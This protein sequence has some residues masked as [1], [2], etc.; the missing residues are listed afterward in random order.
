MNEQT[1]TWVPFRVTLVDRN[2]VARRGLQ[3]MLR[4]LQA[5][6]DP[7]LVADV[8]AFGSAEAALTRIAEQQPNL[9]MVSSDLST[10]V[11]VLVR[12]AGD[13]LVLMLIRSPELG[14]LAAAFKTRAHGFVMEH[15]LSEAT[16]ETAITQLRRGEIPMPSVLAR[17]IIEDASRRSTRGGPPVLTAREAEV[18]RLL[19]DGLSNKQIAREL[20]ISIHGAKRHVANILM[21][22][23]C[24]NRTMAVARAMN[25]RLL[26]TVEDQR[27]YAPP[28]PT[29]RYAGMGVGGA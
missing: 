12:T 18:L 2:Q 28:A 4:A 6:R 5:D 1:A 13:S 25:Q 20:E 14:H 23:N 16:L 26:E 7:P 17:H 15:E 8:A 9:I 29:V 24:P 21:K 11:D 22:L 10:A 3:E 27:D 19:A